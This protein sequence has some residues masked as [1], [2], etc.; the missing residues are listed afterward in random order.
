M[1]RAEFSRVISWHPYRTFKPWDN[2]YVRLFYVFSDDTAVD[3]M[4]NKLLDDARAVNI[5]AAHDNHY[6]FIT[7]LDT[8]DRIEPTNL[9]FYF[10]DHTLSIWMKVKDC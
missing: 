1:I 10:S 9:C 5:K 4:E 7:E 8:I 3:C 2:G 6:C